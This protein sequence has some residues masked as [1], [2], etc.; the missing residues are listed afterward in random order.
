MAVRFLLDGEVIELDAVDPTATVLDHLRYRMRRTGTKEGCAEGDC[1]ACTVLVGTLEGEAVAWR[2]VNACIQF[3]PML[4][5]KALMTVESLG[6]GEGGLNALQCAMAANGSSQCGFCTPGFV[7]SLHGRTI[8]A[9]GCDL[10]VADVIAGNLCRCTGYGPI[11]EAGE[12]A[13]P[14]PQDDAPVVAALKALGR[15]SASGEW[16]GRRWFAPRSAEEL[17]ALLAEHPDARLVA[18]ATDVGLWV[19]KGLRTL[20]TVIFLG[21]V[22]DLGVIEETAGALTLGAGVRYADAHAAIARLHPELGEL[23]RRIGGLQVRN[24]GTVGG[25]IANGSPIG[26]GPPALIALGAELTLRSA[27]GR[28]TMPLE[29]YFVAYGKQDRQP[30]EFVESVRIP[31]PAESAVIHIAKLS[32]RFDSDISAVC[33]AFALEVD[34]GTITAARVAFGGMAA[35]PK[36][37][38]ACEAALIGK[39]FSE[40][41]LTRAAE[42]L[43]EDYQPLSDVRGSSIYRLDAAANLLRRLWLRSQGVAVSVLE[44]EAHDG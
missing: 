15:E 14:C 29:D 8:G 30:G 16:Q 41:T 37:A 13:A 23:V 44:V 22:A 26:D 40:A 31:R 11:I 43:R 5:G 33:G 10:P 20:D 1:G 4:N 27:A 39:P 34:D 3:L 35:T 9:R 17:A 42:A 2:A 24:A 6:G 7:M 12:G 32:R 25:N 19:T 38:G 28:R 36:R 18:G 21:D